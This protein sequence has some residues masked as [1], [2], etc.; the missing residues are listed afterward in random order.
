MYTRNAL[1]WFVRK[2]RGPVSC[3]QYVS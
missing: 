2:A 1:E 3:L